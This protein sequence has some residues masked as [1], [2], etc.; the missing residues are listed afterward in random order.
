MKRKLKLTDTVRVLT[1]NSDDVKELIEIITSDG[2]WECVDMS[3]NNIRMGDIV[4][5]IDNKG[6]N[7]KLIFTM[8]PTGKKVFI[9]KWPDLCGNFLLAMNEF[10]DLFTVIDEGNGTCQNSLNLC[11]RLKGY[12]GK[13]FYITLIGLSYLRAVSDDAMVFQNNQQM[14]TILDSGKIYETG[15]V[16]LFPDLESYMSNPTDPK[17][18]WEKWDEEM[19]TNP[20]LTPTYAKAMDE[21]FIEGAWQPEDGNDPQFNDSANP[22]YPYNAFAPGQI[23]KV[24]NINKLLNVH[25]YLEGDW[26]PDWTNTRQK[27]YF[28]YLTSKGDVNVSFIAD[29]GHCAPCYFSTEGN[30]VMAHKILG[31]LNVKLALGTE[32]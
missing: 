28:L 12:E 6:L 20:I 24:E 27:K 30:A 23:T 19:K 18:A 7:V 31:D 14:L 13:Q 25:R 17:T 16:V 29:S 4:E 11:K 1:Q 5:L 21:L 3:N 15:E 22:C 9:R 10:I 26:T 8:V 32:Y 2:G